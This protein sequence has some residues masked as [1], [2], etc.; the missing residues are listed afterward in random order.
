MS[1]DGKKYADYS[2][3]DLFRMEMESQKSELNRGLLELEKKPGIEVFDS[4]MRSVH[5]IKGAAQ[6]VDVRA[7]VR[8]AHAL[9]EAFLEIQNG[10]L[11]LSRNVIDKLLFAVDV[12]V[13]VTHFSDEEI[14][15]WG[16]KREKV[17]LDI[18]ASLNDIVDGKEDDFFTVSN[19]ID[20]K[21]LADAE[22]E[23]GSENHEANH[24]EIIRVDAL[25]LSKV[26][27]LAAESLVET[28]RFE[29]VKASLFNYKKK[30]NDLLA[31]LDQFSQLLKEQYV[32]DSVKDELNIIIK[33]GLNLQQDL[34]RRMSELDSFE[35]RASA[36]AYTLHNEILS[37]RM[38]PFAIVV[39]AL[40][41][42]V[43]DVAH[44]LN[45][46]VRLRM[47][48]LATL[49]DREVLK[50]ID[51]T[52]VHL[53]QNAI[54]H[55]IEFSEKRKSAG[56]SET[57]T[58]AL[59]VSQTAGMLYVVV[60]DDGR[61]IDVD[62]LRKQLVEK[63]IVEALAVINLTDEEIL[64][65]MFLPGFSTRKIVSEISGRGVGLDVV[66]DAISSLGGTI[67]VSTV[68]GKGTEFRL[69]LPLTISVVR[70]LLVRIRDESYAFPLTDINYVARIGREDIN[71]NKK[72]SYIL[73][74]QKLV[75]LVNGGQVLG[76]DNEDGNCQLDI[77]LVFFGSG[78]SE[79][80]MVVDSLEGE[81]E[82]SIQGVEQ[83]LNKMSHVS[84]ATIKEDGEL[85]LVLD[86]ASMEQM[87]EN[88]RR[89]GGLWE[90]KCVYKAP[91]KK[92]AILVTG[93]GS[94]FQKYQMVLEEMNYNV[95][96]AGNIKDA[97]RK[98]LEYDFD[99]VVMECLSQGKGNAY[100]IAR[101]REE[102]SQH[103]LPVVL[104]GSQNDFNE[105]ELSLNYQSIHFVA[106]EKFDSSV[107]KRV[108][109]A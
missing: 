100:L 79:M 77:D 101:I 25:K 45:K 109:A 95:L 13:N 97:W 40:P 74:E 80:G 85:S 46:S 44:R 7:I 32:H 60:E 42:M 62:R 107:L 39:Q 3:L 70:L 55:G 76:Y 8:I 11:I 105:L 82:L 14:M 108:I 48:G 106:K 36:A 73:R 9:E 33:N 104:V 16:H 51:T 89:N 103:E 102:L 75:Y 71:F 5:S 17:V 49:A 84:S 91:P 69:L 61:G 41:R 37:V 81:T 2:M 98:V 64:D 22:S 18:E 58:I 63:N 90:I 86:V 1:E 6:L 31:Q 27:N 99:L 26:L 54:D 47:T 30:Q 20:Q 34:S 53:I 67:K 57:G 15:G 35:G 68:L 43:R 50:R 19:E 29:G 93:V 92:N 10:K 59:Q 56:K 38:R 87:I 52:I 72:G 96:V 28:K 12:M 66:K 88:I 24:E 78:D 65:F 4:L 83:Y 21:V 23:V 94:F